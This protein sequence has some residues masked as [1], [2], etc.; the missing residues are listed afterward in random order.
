MD[1][2]SDFLKNF[3]KTKK[4]LQIPFPELNFEIGSTKS[5]SN[6]FALHYKD[7]IEP[8]NRR[9]RLSFPFGNNISYVSC[10]RKF[11]LHGNKSI[12]TEI[13]KLNPRE[14]HHF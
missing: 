1:S 13:V 3:E 7:S 6:L 4:C 11:E 12:F 14:F 10:I 8:P 9:S 2:L 5:K